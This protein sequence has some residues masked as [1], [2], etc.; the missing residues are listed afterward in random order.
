MDFCLLDEK[1][2]NATE[3][4]TKNC[5]GVVLIALASMAAGTRIENEVDVQLDIENFNIVAA[6]LLKISEARL[7]RFP[8]KDITNWNCWLATIPAPPL[9]PTGVRLADASEVTAAL[10]D[11]AA[12]V[13]NLN[14]NITCV[15]CS[16]HKMNELS[17][18]LLTEEAQNGVLET[19]NNMMANFVAPMLEDDLIQFQLDRLLNEASTK[20]PHSPAYDPNASSTQYQPLAVPKTESDVT[21]LMLWGCVVL[22]LIVV[23]ALL[24]LIIHCIVQRR[25]HRWLTNM[26]KDQKDHL[27]RVQSLEDSMESELNGSTVSLFASPQIP[28]MLRW[29]MP[30]II[31]GNIALL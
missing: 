2:T 8:M 27:Q 5:F 3:L 13:F 15:D 31:L 10:A 16:G 17:Q 6:A 22:S 11:F 29:S 7:F 4:T 12:S 28:C 19:M 9:D 25:H 21:Y 1:V 18:L 30:V 26:P 24:M 20:C 23:I 14:L